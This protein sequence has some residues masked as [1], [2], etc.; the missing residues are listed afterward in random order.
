MLEQQLKKWQAVYDVIVVGFGGAGATA[1]RFAADNGAKVLLIDSAPEGHEGG[2]TR[3]C[4]QLIMS[5]S[6]PDKIK[7]YFVNLTKPMNYDE[8]MVDVYTCELAQMKDYLKK[9]LDVEPVSV[10]EMIDKQ[11]QKFAGLQSMTPEYPELAGAE[12]FD[13]LLVHEGYSDAALWKTLRQQVVKRTDKIDVWFDAPALHLI[14]ANDD[15]TIVG[16]QIER[17]G[18]KVNV[19]AKGGVV[20]TSGGFENNKDKVQNYVG[21]PF[22]GPVG[23]IY[24]KGIGIDLAIEAGA[25]LWH[26]QATSGS[27]T[28][29]HF[30]EGQRAPLFAGPALNNGSILRIGDDGTRYHREDEVARHGYW[31]NHGLWRAPQTQEHPYL[32]FDQTQFNELNKDDYYQAVTNRA[33]KAASLV[34]LADKI[35]V[36]KEN[37]QQTI[38]RFNE[39][40]AAGND[41]EFHRDI[42]TMRA[43]DDGPYYAVPLSQGMLNTQGGPR[44]NA[45]AEVVDLAGEPIPHLYA[46][47]ELGSIWNGQYQG[48]GDISDCLIFGK[49]AG[50]NA[51]QV[52]EAVISEQQTSEVPVDSS[53][54]GQS[55]MQAAV[56]STKKNQFIGKST[57]GMGDEL[58]VRI[59]VDEQQN[60]QDIE[61]L[62]QEESADYGLKALKELP[63]EMIRQNTI[64]VD[65]VSGA[66]NTSRALKAAVKDALSKITKS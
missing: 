64:E 45:R 23:T 27:M 59:T 5:G 54:L 35:T 48:G 8:E 40:V 20:L 41:P 63:K 44:R 49:I 57:I 12:D 2:N 28:L 66:S 3:Y 11:P 17:A 42:K 24:N 9:Y 55:D 25:D 33:I 37:L 46:A 10:R 22:I 4:G 34:D 7:Q 56:Y 62:K 53:A 19:K 1:A 51:A 58:I 43:F 36:S 52:K 15:R 30:D 18:Q 14:K 21:E 60:L 16:V 61:V 13:F 50:E 38:T 65:A 29:L 26:M 47:G 31:Y 6:E 39:S 32:V